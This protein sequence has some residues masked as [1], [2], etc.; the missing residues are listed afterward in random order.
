MHM[1]EICKLC[2][3]NVDF[4]HLQILNLL[5]KPGSQKQTL[6]V[7]RQSCIFNVCLMIIS[8]QVACYFGL[9]LNINR[10]FMRSVVNTHLFRDSSVCPQLTKSQCGNTT[11]I[12]VNW[13]TMYMY[14]QL[15]DF[16]CGKIR[17][18]HM[19]MYHD[20]NS[21]TVLSPFYCRN[22]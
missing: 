5:R 6:V 2:N 17:L 4:S 15:C 14:L 10:A 20:H 12:L 22:V 16:R 21:S 13:H 1:P 18:K 9:S 8:V 3:C 19:Y 11:W 7:V